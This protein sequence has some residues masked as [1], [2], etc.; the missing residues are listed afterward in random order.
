MAVV[1]ADDFGPSALGYLW[2]NLGAA[3]AEIAE[4]A[5]RIARYA[6]ALHEKNTPERPRELLPE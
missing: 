4:A 3:D 1:P 5:A 6:F 2:V